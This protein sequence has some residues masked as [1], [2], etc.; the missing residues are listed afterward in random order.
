MVKLEKKLNKY[1]KLFNCNIFIF[2]KKNLKVK[3]YSLKEIFKKCDLVCL[4]LSLNKSTK[5]II[6][7]KMY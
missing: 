7:K 4:S 6:D 3:K 5:E 2:E 1:L